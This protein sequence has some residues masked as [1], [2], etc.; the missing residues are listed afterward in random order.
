MSKNKQVMK[1]YV[2]AQGAYIGAFTDDSKQV[3]IDAIQI[4]EPP[5]DARQ[6]LVGGK[7]VAIDKAKYYAELRQAEYPS[8][9]EQLDAIFKGGV[10]FDTM[11]VQIQGIKAKHPKPV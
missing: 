3:P 10:A 2:D 1:H 5:M 6:M 7:W 8:I 9:E 4:D 11:K